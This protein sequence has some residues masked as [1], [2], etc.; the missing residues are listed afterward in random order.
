[1]RER[2]EVKNDIKKYRSLDKEIKKMCDDAKDM[3]YNQ[4]C[5]Q[6]EKLREEHKSKEMHD[7]VKYITNKRR[8][9]LGNSCI[10]SKNG[11]IL[12]EED[13][14]QERWCEYNGELF[15]DDRGEVPNIEQLEGP[16]ILEAQVEK[17]IKSMKKGKSA[18]DDGVT[19]EM[20]QAIDNLGIK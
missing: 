7:K 9:N 18:G 12:F 1:M 11:E 2:K 19:T 14:I 3:W 20:L 13:D 6:I 10:S 15:D 8:R 5:E 4:Q 16:T 17:A